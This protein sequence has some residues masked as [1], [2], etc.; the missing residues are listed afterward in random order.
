LQYG[1]I[2]HGR[3]DDQWQIRGYRVEKLEIEITLRKIANNNAIAVLPIKDVDNAVIQLAAFV[4]AS[5]NIQKMLSEA[6]TFL[7][8]VMIPQ[9]VVPL[10]ILPLNQNGKID[11]SALQVLLSE[12][13]C[14]SSIVSAS[15]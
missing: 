2:Y 9:R 8:S 6:K 12:L 1:L 7:P 5:I 4:H 10:A 11:Y 14:H 13:D 15:I 3:L